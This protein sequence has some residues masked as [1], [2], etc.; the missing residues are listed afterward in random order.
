MECN[1]ERRIEH[2]L[3]Y[4]WPVWFA[5]N[6][7]GMLTQ[8]QMVDVSS[9]GAAL[10]CH[11]DENCPYPG[12]HITARFSIPRFAEGDCFDMANYTRGG[13]VC[14]VDEVNSF[15]RRVA[16]QFAEPL[17][18]KPGEQA[19]SQAEAEQRLNAITI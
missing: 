18:L 16:V 17:P 13:H 15:L 8:G 19:D 5:E 12:Q 10:T 14:R 2:R 1:N 3:R 6:L 4:H 9:G 7:G 11:A